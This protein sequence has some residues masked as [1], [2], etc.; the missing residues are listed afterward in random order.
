[1]LAEGVPVHYFSENNR[2]WIVTNIS[3]ARPSSG[4]LQVACKPGVWIEP[5][6]VAAKLRVVPG[7]LVEYYS[8]SHLAWLPT[9][10]SAV[11]PVGEVK[12]DVDKRMWIQPSEFDKKLRSSASGRAEHAEPHFVEDEPI[13]Y[14]SVTEGKWIDTTIRELGSLEELNKRRTWLEIDEATGK[15]RLATGCG[16]MVAHATEENQALFSSMDLDIADVLRNGDMRLVSGLWLL[17]RA[18][19]TWPRRWRVKRSQDMPK[20]A[21]LKPE[22]AEQLLLQPLQTSA[23]P[24]PRVV[25]LSYRWLSPKHPDPEGHQLRWLATFLEVHLGC[26]FGEAAAKWTP[27][28]SV[29]PRDQLDVGVMWDFMSLA[30][31]PRIGKEQKRFDRG[32]SAINKVYGSAGSTITVQLT[33]TPPG[34]K[35]YHTSGWCRFEEAISGIIK[36]PSFLCDM[37]EQ[38]LISQT[39][40]EVAESIAVRDKK[41]YHTS[42]RCRFEEAV[43]GI[44]K[45]PSFLCDMARKLILDAATCSPTSVLIERN[46]DLDLTFAEAMG[47]RHRGSLQDFLIFTSNHAAGRKPVLH[48]DDIEAILKSEAVTFTNGSDVDTVIDKYRNFFKSVAEKATV[49]NFEAPMEGQAGGGVATYS[50]A[51][52][53]HWS[54]EEMRTF[55]KSLIEFRRCRK[56][57][58]GGHA[59]TAE[60]ALIL[61]DALVVMPAL[62]DVDFRWSQNHWTNSLCED[63]EVVLRERLKSK[64]EL[65]VSFPQKHLIRARWVIFFERLRLRCLMCARRGAGGR[66]D[67]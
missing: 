48:P 38:K 28:T 43:S 30:Q 29:P 35:G 3:A 53:V 41:R 14:F 25:A 33:D 20:K 11:G 5:H 6:E 57:M 24:V 58:L 7:T 66:R 61:A 55:S 8:D 15:L 64:P 47:F 32:F 18:K 2:N 10:I 40:S 50:K 67:R 4:Q 52:A 36:S 59:L 63:A 17:K 54:L 27:G 37:S 23:G 21:F 60:N 13:Q 22:I 9:R 51:K 39:S 1:M 19:Q 45:I 26:L 46:E 31:A 62:Q 44:F 42:G 49:L 65:R 16:P 12:V 56:L 34:V